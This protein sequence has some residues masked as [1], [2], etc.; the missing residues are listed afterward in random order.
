MLAGSRLLQRTNPVRRHVSHGKNQGTR[1]HS[2]QIRQKVP[3]VS[4]SLVK[5]RAP[6]GGISLAAVFLIKLHS[7]SLSPPRLFLLISSAQGGLP[8]PI[9]GVL[10]WDPDPLEAPAVPGCAMLA[11]FS[12]GLLFG[13]VGAKLKLEKE[14]GNNGFPGPRSR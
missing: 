14:A 13:N 1:A 7:L 12:A 6:G 9:L 10:A 4:S 8:T 11:R 5:V 3:C 2:R